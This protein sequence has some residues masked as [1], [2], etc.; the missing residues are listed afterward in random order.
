MLV[1]SDVVAASRGPIVKVVAVLGALRFGARAPQVFVRI[2]HSDV[3]PLLR[4]SC[5]PM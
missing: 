1:D 2:G 5:R 3:G 4:R